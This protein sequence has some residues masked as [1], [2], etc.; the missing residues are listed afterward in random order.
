MKGTVGRVKESKFHIFNENSML[1]LSTLVDA[2]GKPCAA[3]ALHDRAPYSDLSIFQ[4]SSSIRGVLLWRLI[5]LKGE[6]KMSGTNCIKTDFVH[7]C[8]TT[9][10]THTTGITSVR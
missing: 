8:L 10:I 5:R 9:G 1:A 6:L 4:G 3:R 2:E 7:F